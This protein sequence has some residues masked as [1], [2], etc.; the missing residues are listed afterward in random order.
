MSL[1]LEKDLVRVAKRENNQ[2]R[3]YLVVNCLQAKHIPV[4]PEKSFAMF[5]ALAQLLSDAYPEEKLL[6]V[7]FAETATAIGARTAIDLNSYYMQTT[8]ENMEGV[9][10]LYFTESHSHATEQKLVK[11]DLDTVIHEIDR[12]VFVE[13]EVT[14]GNTILKIMNLIRKEYPKQIAFSVASLLNGMD[15]NAQSVY[16]SNGIAIHYLVKTD[17]RFYSDT[18]DAFRGDGTYVSVAK[19]AEIPPVKRIYAGGC[20]NARRLVRGADYRAACEGLW[21]QVSEKFTFTEKD[22]VLVL[23]TE[24]FMYPAIYIA[25]Q[26]SLS[27]CMVKSH[28]TTRSPITVSTEKE[29]P[30]HCR[31]ELRSMYDPKRKTFI[32]DLEKYDK[33]IVLTD[34]AKESEAGIHDLCY[35]LAENGNT[36]ITVI[37]WC[38]K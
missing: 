34:S 2:K 4:E 24:E 37:R 20:R 12:I 8:R 3:N 6:L 21:E 15:E 10:Y 1:Y 11:T 38:E 33:V 14:T 28:S 36:D 27:G 9:E 29:Y 17:H 18:A 32:Y 5:D 31:Y 26:L 13:D 25:H 19:E 22:T 30:V 16:A 35:A 7:G 23:G